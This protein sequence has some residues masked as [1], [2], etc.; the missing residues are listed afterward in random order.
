[1]SIEKSETRRDRRLTCGRSIDI[2]QCDVLQ[3]AEPEYFRATFALRS[4]PTGWQITSVQ[5]T[6]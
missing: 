6:D 5:V 4:E 1:L 2:P 3:R